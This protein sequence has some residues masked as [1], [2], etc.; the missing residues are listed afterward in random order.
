M[1]IAKTI[2]LVVLAS[3]LLAGCKKES[4]FEPE[5]AQDYYP[6]AVGNTFIYR[7]DSV[8]AAVF[9]TKLDTFYYSAKDSTVATFLD[10]NNRLSYRFFRYVTDS[11]RTKP[12]QYRSTYYVTPT[13]NGVEV[14]EGDLRYLKLVSPVKDFVSWKGNAYIET[15][16]ATSPYL[17]LD[18]WNYQYHHVKMP[19]TVRAGTFETTATVM[20]QDY[21]FP[22]GPFN[23]SYPRQDRDYSVEVYAKGVGLIYKEFLHWTWQQAFNGFDANSYG[24]RLHLIEYRR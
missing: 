17:Y 24:I 5:K 11:A 21:F 12:W 9:G 4:D 3:L 1:A 16:S 8:V 10:N 22:E 15:K 2:G 18:E 6:L 23:P 19:Y 13:E 7:M 20:Q 14:V